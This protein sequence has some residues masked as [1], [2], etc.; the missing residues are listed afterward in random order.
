MEIASHLFGDVFATDAA[1]DGRGT[2][3]HKNLFTY[4]PNVQ[5]W[6]AHDA[7]LGGNNYNAWTAKYATLGSGSSISPTTS[8]SRLGIPTS[9]RV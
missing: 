6:L 1:D 3:F 9:R 7:K 4:S 2:D 8:L 5:A